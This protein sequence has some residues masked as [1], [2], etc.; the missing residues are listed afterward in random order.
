MPANEAPLDPT[1][2]EDAPEEMKNPARGL[3]DEVVEKETLDV[4]EDP[5]TQEPQ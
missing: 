2:N 5:G 4:D 1:E 3:S